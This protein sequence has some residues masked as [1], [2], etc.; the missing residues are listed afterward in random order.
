MKGM[1]VNYIREMKGNYMTVQ[2]PEAAAEGYE[3]HMLKSNH[4]PGLLKVKIKYEDGNPIYCY[5]ITSRQPLSRLLE[6]RAMTREEIGYLLIQLHDALTAMERYF[7]KEDG[8]LLEP[9]YI[10]VEPELFQVG[11]CYIPG[12]SGDFYGK[13]SLL[14][15]MILKHIDHRNRECVVLAYGLYQESLKENYG[16]EDL[17][18]LLPGD[19]KEAVLRSEKQ[20]CREKEEYKENKAEERSSEAPAGQEQQDTALRELVLKQALFWLAASFL[21]PL[22]IWILRGTSLLMELSYL[23]IGASVMLLLLFAGYDFIFLLFRKK[24]KTAV[25]EEEERHKEDSWRILYEDEEEMEEEENVE[26][27]STPAGEAPA[28]ENFQTVLLS[29]C[30][31]PGSTHRLEGIGPDT[32][33]IPILYFPFVIGKHKGLADHVLDRDTVSRFHLRCDKKEEICTI[34]DLNSTNGTAVRGHL[35]AANETAEVYPGDEVEIA[36]MRYIWR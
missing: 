24:G 27:A 4:I 21:V 15:Q 10:Y 34:T 33:D 26:T 23:L 35:L 18:A 17:M 9:E 30:S 20:E 32:E 16:L 1:T 14:L 7:L 6:S 3:G 19:G 29:D 22:L 31:F 2:F 8:I 36:Q 25:K 13:L 28:Q 11:F 12:G 5:D